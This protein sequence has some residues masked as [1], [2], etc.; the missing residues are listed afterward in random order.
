VYLVV[1][2]GG[3][4]PETRRIELGPGALTI[5]RAETCEIRVDVPGVDQEH[6]KIS[7]VA[8]IALGPDCAIGDVPLDAG[9]RRLLMPGDEIQIGSVVVA[10]EGDDP[11]I[12]A[13]TQAQ[14]T[15]RMGSVASLAAPRVRVVEGANFG[16]ELFL[17]D[18]GREYVIG[19]GAQCDLAL[20]DR[21]VSREHVKLMRKGYAVF[22]RDLS[23]TRGSWLGRSAVY[24]GSTVEWSRPRMLRVGAT[25]LSLE[26]PE[27]I[28]KAA[29]GAQASAPMTPPP[30]SRR[31][32]AGTGAPSSGGSS[33][34]TPAPSQPPPGIAEAAGSGADAS[35]RALGA[36]SYDVTP[37]PPAHSAPASGGPASPG[38]DAPPRGPAPAPVAPHALGPLPAA[39]P[40]RTAWKKTGP[41]IGKASG[42]LLLALAGLVILGGLFVVFSL[43]E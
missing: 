3:C 37:P 20:E 11:S 16:D 31:N 19:R 42:L 15:Q 35:T 40:A 10:L 1:P 21:E 23:S 30:R 13:P 32:V 34:L 41:T 43:L 2:P 18:E 5:G 17:T 36:F 25:V 33:V 22:V 27:E 28:R 7:E 24:T 6:A 14:I 8:L 29:P 39:S 26:L 38:R 12:A 9:A 4:F